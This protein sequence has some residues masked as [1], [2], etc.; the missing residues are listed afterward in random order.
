MAILS[1]KYPIEYDFG[2][3]GE[4]VIT[5]SVNG[6]VLFKGYTYTGKVDISGICQSYM[7]ASI[8]EV[9]NETISEGYFLD[10][11]RDSVVKSFFVGRSTGAPAAIFN[12]ANDY[13]NQYITRY[14]EDY[15][16]S[17]SVTGKYHPDDLIFVDVNSPNKTAVIES[18][19]ITGNVSGFYS[20]HVTAKQAQLEGDGGAI[21]EQIT[22]DRVTPLGLTK[23]AFDGE[24]YMGIRSPSTGPSRIVFRS[25][26]LI[27]WIPIQAPYSNA[28]NSINYLNGNFLI[29]SNRAI[30]ISD[31]IT[32][33]ISLYNEDNYYYESVYS[34]GYYCVVGNHV[35]GGVYVNYSTDLTSWSTNGF[36][37]SDNI[38]CIAT[39]GNG[40]LMLAGD[41]GVIFDC[42][43]TPHTISTT[44]FTS[45]GSSDFIPRKMIYENGKFIAVGSNNSISEAIVYVYENNRWTRYNIG[46]TRCTSVAYGSGLYCFVLI[47]D[48]VVLTSDFVN[49]ETINIDNNE[50]TD[51]IFN[52]EKFVVVGQN[53]Y[54]YTIEVKQGA[55]ETI[56]VNGVEYPIVYSEGCERFSLY[57]VNRIGGRSQLLLEGKEV[58]KFGNDFYRIQT[59]YDETDPASFERRTI[60]N[61]TTQSFTLYTGLLTDEESNK[62]DDLFTSPRVWLH[63]HENDRIM[64]VYITDSNVTRKTYSNNRKFT[65]TINVTQAQNHIRR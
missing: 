4:Y 52:G 37:R 47:D 19:V 27:Q 55:I 6:N 45:V 21:I 39:D 50:F 29:G 56:S 62:M 65:Y 20:A 25:S 40:R 33:N 57:W 28:A 43:Q 1:P 41:N 5:D 35:T 12:V 44:T 34:N 46:N 60:L 17:Y 38:R 11:E 51:V 48:G 18:N 49:F 3:P 22:T 64:S 16:T 42:S 7:N 9:P 8:V 24:T 63:D 13:N 10:I 26:D 14:T 32:V 58:E 2:A 36:N 15:I 30:Y 23:I 59:N 53:R 31:K 54:I 61:N